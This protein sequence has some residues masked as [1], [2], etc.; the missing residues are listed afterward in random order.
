MALSFYEQKLSLGVYT[1]IIGTIIAG[2]VN[3]YYIYKVL[4]KVKYNI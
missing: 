2:I 3:N 4:T 1:I